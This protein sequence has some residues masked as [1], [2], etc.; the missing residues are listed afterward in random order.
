MPGGPA[1]GPGDRVWR[2]WRV[3]NSG[4]F[5]YTL[6]LVLSTVWHP[7][8]HPRNVPSPGR[9]LSLRF[10]GPG[11]TPGPVQVSQPAGARA[12][13]LAQAPPRPRSCAQRHVLYGGGRRA[14][15]RCARGPGGAGHRQLPRGR[16]GAQ[17]ARGASQA[18]LPGAQGAR[19]PGCGAPAA[20]RAAQRRGS[21]FSAAVEGARLALLARQRGCRCT[22]P[23]HMRRICSHAGG[24]AQR[25]RAPRAR[26][27]RR[28][29]GRRAA[30]ARRASLVGCRHR[31]DGW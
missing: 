22:H 13:P 2:F 1:R 29:A 23:A 14:R 19:P 24:H 17:G 15:A 28:F 9:A 18:G 30:P 10:S 31:K 26:V 3:W 5:G 8:E 4:E 20:A 25:A 6:T 11:A 16:P 7:W 21:S 27:V 12:C